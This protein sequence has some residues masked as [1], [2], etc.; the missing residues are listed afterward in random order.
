MPEA[1]FDAGGP[2]GLLSSGRLEAFSDGVLA[3][4]ITLLI[5]DVKVPDATEGQLPSK[6]ARQWPSYTAYAVTFLIIG[7]IWVN[8]HYLFDRVRVVT[9]GVLYLNIILLMSV[10]FLPFPTALLAEY[11]REDRNS[12]TAAAV[13]S[14]NMTLIGLAFVL[15]WYYLSR[16]PEL[17]AEGTSAEDAYV[18]MKRSVVGPAVYGA[19][20]GLAFVSAP[21]CLAAYAAMALYFMVW[22]AR[23]SPRGTEQTEQRQP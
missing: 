22:R 1:P 5:L 20:I 15:L 8:H 23:P 10:A 13:Y 18:A 16:N 6:L 14:T 7:I 9:R 2:T 17:L 12:H 11:L 19:T 21:A 4:A 3:I